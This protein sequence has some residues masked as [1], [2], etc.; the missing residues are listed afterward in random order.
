M[1]HPHPVPHSVYVRRRIAVGLLAL[2]VLLVGLLVITRI[3][4]GDAGSDG[5]ASTD[6][7]EASVL[8]AD[9]GTTIADQA[10][11]ATTT[12]PSGDTVSTDDS[13]TTGGATTVP[14]TAG[15]AVTTTVTLVPGAVAPPSVDA[16]AYTVYD[17][18]GD[19][20]LAESQAD[21]PRAVGSL[22]KLLTAHVV[23]EAGDLTKVV[24]VPALDMDPQES[25]IGLYE[26]EE[27][28]RD[29]L[30]RAML[31]VSANDAARTL[32][33]DNAGSE[34][35]FT[36]KMNAAAQQLGLTS[37]VAANATGLDAA[38]AQS[39]A[40]EMTTLGALLM[41]DPDFRTT[42]ART[43]ARLHG[44]TYPSTNDLLTAYV[45]ADGIKTGSTTQAG[46]C[47]LG[48]ATRDGRTIMVAVLGSSTDA[49][50]VEAT[51][52]LLDWAFANT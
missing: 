49:S 42:V 34:A 5:S 48:S 50:R 31:I 44:Q 24:T 19:R 37:T 45:G 7:S 14:S 29:V 27:L 4:G 1:T 28:P 51:S 38:G 39:T 36:E 43:E 18:T 8:E 25:A 23:M 6:G 41:Q 32:A 46:Y 17:L 33:I 12:A 15:D 40:R 11:T 52:A 16:A 2:A 20:W 3:A 30:L 26:G 35:A 47:L 13:G 10:S 22:M 21:S 9:A